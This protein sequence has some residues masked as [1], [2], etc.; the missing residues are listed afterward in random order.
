M[1]S[2]AACLAQ[3][4]AFICPDERY[5]PRTALPGHPPEKA[6]SRP[7][8]SSAFAGVL[9][10]PSSLMHQAEF[11]RTLSRAILLPLLVITAL[12][13]VAVWQVGSLLSAV[14]WV[15]H[16]DRVISQARLTQQ[17]ITDMRT[18]RRSYMLTGDPQFLQLYQRTEASF[19]ATLER[20]QQLTAD[21]Q[22]QQQRLTRIRADYAQWATSMLQEEALHKQG[23]TTPSNVYIM[24]TKPMMDDL[25]K[26][27]DDLISVEESLRYA[28]TRATQQA[29]ARALVI[30]LGM[31]LLFG[32][33]LAFLNHR[34]LLT[35]S[36]NYERSFALAQSRTEALRASEEQLATT[37]RSIGDGVI[38]TDAQGR[39][40][41]L[42]AV[43]ERLTGWRQ[44][45]AHGKDLHEVFT[46]VHE[47]T[48][49]PVESPVT[50]VIR[51][52]M[53]IGLAN[54]TLLLSRDGTETAI[55]DT[56]API[57][58]DQNDLLGVVLVF[59]DVTER[60]RLETQ[61]LQAQKLE[62]VGRLAGGIAHD[63]NNLLTAILGHTEM[64]EEE[65]DA[66]CAVHVHLCGIRQAGERAADLTRQLL[67]F[68]RRQ[69]IEP[70]VI[71]LNALILS[72]DTL[73][74]RL[75]GENI[76]IVFL[77]ASGLNA[78]KVDTGQFTQILVNLVINARDAML[79]G[80]KITIET[81]NA[82][83]D[84]DYAHQH[85]GVEPGEYVLLAISDTGTGIE[86]A[87]RLHIF[88]PFF[89]TKEK[90]R[91]TGLGL[92][93]VYGIVKQAGGHIWLYSEPGKGTTFKI[94][95][96]R[97]LETSQALAT[98]E[99]FRVLPGGTETLL[100]VEDEP[101]VR[102][103]AAS[104]LR[105]RGYTVLEAANGAEALRTAQDHAEEVALLI[106]DVVM[107]LLGGKELA[108]RLQATRPDMKVLYVSGYTENTVVHH[109][110]LEPGISF[111]SK[112]FTPASLARKVRDILD[113]PA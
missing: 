52:G 96:P 35:L 90:G 101:A 59:H 58:N 56:G 1:Q 85:D 98:P 60:K 40:T 75:I 87:I 43:A 100:L 10:L 83:L 91:G 72:L 8:H 16:T 46:I 11:K 62:S 12:A 25:R 4:K 89:T 74:R 27:F 79:D 78:V 18:G 7:W 23:K 37:L 14:R 108:D 50:K 97:S 53:V 95:L 107:P 19:D 17:Q 20:L 67:A 34:Q 45:E 57:R 92:A 13:G 24:R 77:L 51:D 71:D 26:Q 65:F 66:D 30:A 15:D 105:G 93:T 31:A 80:G 112:P 113:D 42:N 81:S 94:Y 103:L 6:A 2:S 28:R 99:V 44:S 88:E 106:T 86:E 82:T 21:N 41:F 33:L 9:F 3:D 68:A 39:I 63:F 55:D 70:K 32:L 111:L 48:R 54:H 47:Q 5:P 69:V 61:L 22:D 49:Q 104:A 76:E 64:A 29:T 36:G 84:A 73:L 110:V 109:G 38:A 102:A